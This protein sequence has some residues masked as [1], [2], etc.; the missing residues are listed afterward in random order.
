MAR[1]PWGRS[2]PFEDIIRWQQEMGNLMQNR[3]QAGTG[4]FPP[5][6]LYDD[7][8]NFRLRSELPGLD[9]AKL[10]V[11]VAGEV[12]TIKGG[13]VEDELAGSYH[14]RERGW[15]DFNRSLTLPD[16]IN[17]DEVRAS[18]KNGVLEVTLPRAA[19]VLPRTVTVDAQ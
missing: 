10:D 12:L 18:Y 8:I 1:Y 7:G 13:R 17:V 9:L 2:N 3:N 11:T 19:E 15:E 5:A 4:D 16:T 14:R 6:N